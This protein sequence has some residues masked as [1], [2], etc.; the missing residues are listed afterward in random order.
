MHIAI[1]SDLESSGGAAIAATRLSQGFGKEGHEVTRIVFARGESNPLWTTIAVPQP[2]SIIFRGLRKIVSATSKT[3]LNR[4][5]WTR[6]IQMILDQVKPDVI[7]I[8]NLH[9][10][11]KFGW[12]TNIVEECVKHGPTIWTLHD[13]WSFTGRCTYNYDCPKY[14]TGC[15]HTCP[16]PDQY[17]VMAP[18]QIAGAWESKKQLFLSSSN[19][20]AVSPSRWLAELAENGMWRNHTVKVIRN[21]LPLDVFQP[22]SR[23]VSRETLGLNKEGL[24][25][26]IVS[27]SLEDPRKGNQ[28]AVEAIKKLSDPSLTIL[29]MGKGKPFT[30]ENG[31]RIKELG[32]V[33]EDRTKVLAYSAAS[34]VIHPA[35][36]DNL[37][38]VVSE[39]ISCGTPVLAFSVGGLPEMIRPQQTGWLANSITPEGLENAL[40]AAIKDLQAG[41][42]LR[43]SCRKFAE[44]EYSIE[45]QVNSYLELFH[46]G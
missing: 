24:I 36:M 18:N 40:V 23:A 1:I 26:L 34:F 15:D 8:H 28:I 37:P 20:A 11:Q 31:L 38:N 14:L 30:E 46:S 42:D 16:T 39:S 5:H 10:A 35:L 21:G 7:N 9:G 33:N 13:M 29:T 2:T 43:E 3:K 41:I 12:S 27:T 45:K 17:P 44:A 25:A 6:K 32:L 22:M 4:Y 19:L